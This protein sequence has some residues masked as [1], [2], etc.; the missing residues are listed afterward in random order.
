MA[1]NLSRVQENAWKKF[2]E[3]HMHDNIHGSCIN[4]VAIN[5]KSGFIGVIAT[6]RR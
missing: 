4:H 3:W 2:L 6:V 1:F 5:V